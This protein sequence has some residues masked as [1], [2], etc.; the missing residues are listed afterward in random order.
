MSAGM[1]ISVPIWW[2][3]DEKAAKGVMTAYI[4]YDATADSLHVGN[5]ATIMMMHRLQQNQGINPLS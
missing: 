5:L 3:W 2:L 1:C 4:G